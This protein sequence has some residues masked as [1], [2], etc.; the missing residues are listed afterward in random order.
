MV[1]DGSIT[2]DQFTA[3]TDPFLTTNEVGKGTGLGLAS[4]YGI[5]QQSGGRIWVP[6]AL[7][8]GTTFPILLPVAIGIDTSPTMSTT[9]LDAQPPTV[10]PRS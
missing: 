1:L 3:A 10:R 5:A 6:S 2:Y 9:H 4:V 7:G 8:K